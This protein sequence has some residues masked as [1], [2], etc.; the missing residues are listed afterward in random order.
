MSGVSPADRERNKRIV[1]AF[2]VLADC[3]DLL[4]NVSPETRASKY[5]RSRRQMIEDILTGKER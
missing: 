5:F 2:R 3:I 4:E 1:R